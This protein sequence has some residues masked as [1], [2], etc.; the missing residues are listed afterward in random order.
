MLVPAFVGLVGVMVQESI[1]VAVSSALTTSFGGCVFGPNFRA[2]V[3]VA[4]GP[5]L[6]TIFVGRVFGPMPMPMPMRGWNFGLQGN[7][8]R[9][10]FSFI[11][12]TLGGA[13]AA[14]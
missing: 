5:S 11:K 14:S 13:V 6:S 3:V 10:S 12:S 1:M 8:R 7:A 9:R 4:V 2:C